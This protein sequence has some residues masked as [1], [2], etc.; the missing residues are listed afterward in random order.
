VLNRAGGIFL[1]LNSQKPGN[2]RVFVSKVEFLSETVNNF[3]NLIGVPREQE[4]IIHIDHTH[5]SRRDE[6]ALLDTA[7]K[8]SEV[9]PAERVLNQLSGDC[10]SS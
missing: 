5:D 2:I 3:L 6:E 10:R 4:T 9:K 7:E 1:K 8:E